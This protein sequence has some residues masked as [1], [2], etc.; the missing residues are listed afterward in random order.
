MGDDFGD[1][2]WWCGEDR[3]H[4]KLSRAYT[5]SFHFSFFFYSHIGVQVSPIPSLEV[6]GAWSGARGAVARQG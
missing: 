1:L 2:R 6:M 3:L 4:V 5:Y